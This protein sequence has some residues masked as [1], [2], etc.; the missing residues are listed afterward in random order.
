M[1]P[2]A[3]MVTRK[4]LRGVPDEGTGENGEVAVIRRTNR[5]EEEKI[6]Q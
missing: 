1:S 4:G 6:R 5:T 2:L 3:D